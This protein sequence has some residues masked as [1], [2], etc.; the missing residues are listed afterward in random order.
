[1][2]KKLSSGYVGHVLSLQILTN[3]SGSKFVAN[4][5]QKLAFRERS[6]AAEFSNA[7]PSGFG[8]A[9]QHKTVRKK[10]SGHGYTTASAGRM[11]WLL[12]LG[13][14]R[15]GLFHVRASKSRIIFAV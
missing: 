5:S 10:S 2:N 1:L 11:G 7:V 3:A 12:F 15:L 6:V 8:L 9:G 14:L 4:A 13:A